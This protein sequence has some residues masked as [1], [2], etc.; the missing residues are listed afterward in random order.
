MTQRQ[1]ILRAASIA[2]AAGEDWDRFVAEFA[3]YTDDVK[4]QCISSNADTVQIAQG[5]AR[6]CASLLRLFSECRVV[7][8]QITENVNG[9]R[10]R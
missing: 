10:N 7:A 8:D 9:K 1:L 6:E 5:R 2:R 3:A 4:N